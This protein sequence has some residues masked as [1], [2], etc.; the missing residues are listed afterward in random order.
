M[1]RIPNLPW[2]NVLAFVIGLIIA[3]VV[4][5]QWYFGK[6]KGDGDVGNKK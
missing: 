1:F 3:A 4:I 5:T 2:P 6:D